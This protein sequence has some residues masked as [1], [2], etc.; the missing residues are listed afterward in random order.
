[1]RLA[2]ASFFVLGVA[3]ACGKFIAESA[4]ASDAGIGDATADDGADPSA[5]GD[6]Y[7]GDSG[8]DAI[9]VSK[10]RVVFVS[11]AQ[12]A[13][14]MLGDGG[15]DG[16]CNAEANADAAAPTVRG[17]RFIAWLST[18]TVA[19][20]DRLVPSD[21]PYQRTD[22][23]AVAIDFAAL[24]S[25]ALIMPINRDST[26]AL[27]GSSGSKVWTG[28]GPNGAATAEHCEGWTSKSDGKD[29]TY[30]ELTSTTSTWTQASVEA[31]DND[32]HVYCIEE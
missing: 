17:K 32:N 12:V 29:G 11:K 6:A 10:T 16:L 13:G 20:K 3:S 22:G 2:L 19:A 27:W 14:D 28:T 21:A 1:M 15:A 26:G 9:V 7:G 24:T 25:G 5:T 23:N 4:N 18:P 31:C 8:A 30:G